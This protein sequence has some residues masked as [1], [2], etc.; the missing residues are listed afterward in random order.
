[1]AVARWGVRSGI[2]SCGRLAGTLL[3]HGLVVDGRGVTGGGARGVMLQVFWGFG[4]AC[5]V[6]FPR[7]ATGSVTCYTR[8]GLASLIPRRILAVFPLTRTTSE[9][10]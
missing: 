7:L 3:Q 1:M 6:L 2:G 5:R 8:A 10:P 4:V 9:G